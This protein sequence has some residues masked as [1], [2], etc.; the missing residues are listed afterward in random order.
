MKGKNFIYPKRFGMEDQFD[1]V[2]FVLLLIGVTIIV[3]RIH[4]QGKRT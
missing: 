1:M 2:T 4:I 3:E